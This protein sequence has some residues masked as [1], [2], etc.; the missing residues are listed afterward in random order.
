M[1]KV[2]IDD[3]EILNGHVTKQEHGN[4]LVPFGDKLLC[5]RSNWSMGQFETENGRITR[6]RVKYTD[7]V[8]YEGEVELLLPVKKVWVLN[9]ETIIR[10]LKDENVPRSAWNGMLW[11]WEFKAIKGFHDMLDYQ[12]T[13]HKVAMCQGEL[14]DDSDSLNGEEATH[15]QYITVRDYMEERWLWRAWDFKHR[16]DWGD[17]CL[18]IYKVDYDS[19]DEAVG[20]EFLDDNDIN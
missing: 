18:Q 10:K 1:S 17:D 12:I 2:A 14:S 20:E 16:L 9:H 19:Y 7:D 6:M 5:V 15:L 11:E 3:K 13:E 4:L 8:Y